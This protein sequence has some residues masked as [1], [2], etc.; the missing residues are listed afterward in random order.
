MPVFTVKI[1]NHH[2]KLV[3]K[4][5]SRTN[6][7]HLVVDTSVTYVFPVKMNLSRKYETK[8]VAKVVFVVA[9]VVVFLELNLLVDGFGRC[10]NLRKQGGVGIR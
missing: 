1:K 5:L 10:W 7:S 2:T 8:V 4:L 3:I 6:N 9:V